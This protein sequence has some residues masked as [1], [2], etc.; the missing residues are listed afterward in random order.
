MS[1]KKQKW[2]IT[3]DNEFKYGRVGYHFELSNSSRCGGYWFFVEETKTVYLYSES[4]QFGSCSITMMETLEDK[5][6]KKFRH[7]EKVVFE[8]DPSVPLAELLSRDMSVEKA[9]ELISKNG[10]L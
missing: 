7:A 3:H 2:V 6:L 10:W 4:V 9:D 8:D 1:G 5:V